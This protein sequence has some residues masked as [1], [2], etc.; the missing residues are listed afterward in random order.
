MVTIHLTS[1]K[2]PSLS[3]SNG[4]RRTLGSIRKVDR[5]LWRIRKEEY[6]VLYCVHRRVRKRERDHARRFSR[7][8]V[9]AAPLDRVAAT[10]ATSEIP[11]AR[12]CRIDRLISVARVAETFGRAVVLAG[13][14][15]LF[16]AERSAR[17]ALVRGRAR[18]TGEV[19]DRGRGKEKERP[20]R[21]RRRGRGP[22]GTRSGVS[23]SCPRGVRARGKHAT[24]PGLRVAER[25][26]SA[27]ATAM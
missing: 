12:C 3:L 16:R 25:P 5:S 24:F 15:Y 11:A 10:T 22:R 18:R 4:R 8:P 13:V 19:S 26:A 14:F 1:T 27:N 17:L 6:S 7:A 21:A 9:T 20:A 2:R 23:P